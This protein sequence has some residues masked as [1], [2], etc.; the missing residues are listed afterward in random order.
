MRL[1]YNNADIKQM[2]SDSKVCMNAGLENEMYKTNSF[3]MQLHEIQ[4]TAILPKELLETACD[5]L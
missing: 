3:P 5:H 1:Q 2:L 4:P